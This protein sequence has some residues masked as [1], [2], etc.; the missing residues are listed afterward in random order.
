MKWYYGEE[1][2]VDSEKTP[3]NVLILFQLNSVFTNSLKL[4]L[5]SESKGIFSATFMNSENSFLPYPS[6]F[7]Y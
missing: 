6:I 4:L 1:I 7:T 2:L 5:I 3:K